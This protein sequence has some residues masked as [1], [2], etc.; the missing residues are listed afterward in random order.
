VAG[1]HMPPPLCLMLSCTSLCHLQWSMHQCPY[2]LSKHVNRLCV[3]GGCPAVCSTLFK[4]ADTGVGCGGPLVGIMELLLLQGGGAG[5]QMLQELH[6]ERQGLPT[7]MTIPQ[8][9]DKLLTGEWGHISY[10]MHWA[11]WCRPG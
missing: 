7:R 9:H 10:C 2:L 8:L 1:A 6:T 5:R 4:A 11:V 3:A